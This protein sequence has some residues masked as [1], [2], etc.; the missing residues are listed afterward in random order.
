[1]IKFTAHHP[2]H[3]LEFILNTQIDHTRISENFSFVHD[4]CR[5]DARLRDVISLIAWYFTCI[6]GQKMGI[7]DHGYVAFY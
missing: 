5:A 1:M 4:A 2:R 3:N 6:A 7:L